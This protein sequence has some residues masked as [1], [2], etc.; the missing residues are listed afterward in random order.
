MDVVVQVSV[1]SVQLQGLDSF[2]VW[3]IPCYALFYGFH[4][5]LNREQKP[6]STSC[7][8]FWS[9]RICFCWWFFL[10]VCLVGFVLFSPIA[11]CFGGGKTP[12]CI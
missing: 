12:N 3:C 10:F 2:A 9:G 4:E 7:A 6:E 8:R 11:N 5:I 1:A